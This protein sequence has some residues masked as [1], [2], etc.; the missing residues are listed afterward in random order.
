MRRGYFLDP[1]VRGLE[2]LDELRL[3]GLLLVKLVGQ[4]RN[5]FLEVFDMRL[6]RYEVFT[7]LDG[8]PFRLIEESVLVLEVL[9]QKLLLLLELFV[10][11]PGL[12]ERGVQFVH[13]ALEC[14]SVL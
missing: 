10:L 3:L 7:E 5:L 14:V 13:L 9:S 2:L 1:L 8:I 4:L 11:V 12:G 6:L